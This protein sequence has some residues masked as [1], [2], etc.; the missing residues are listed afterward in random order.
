MFAYRQSAAGASSSDVDNVTLN[1]V[2]AGSL[3]VVF[4]YSFYSGGSYGTVTCSDGTS[5]SECTPAV[6]SYEYIKAF[7]QY[8][9]GGG[10]K[11]Y[12]I[13]GEH[14]YYGVCAFEF[15]Y[16]GSCKLDAQ[17]QGYGDAT[18]SVAT[19]NITTTGAGSELVIA[20]AVSYA[21]GNLNTPR[22]N[23][24]AAD[25]SLDLAIGS[26]D[27]LAWYRIVR[28]TFTGNASCTDGDSGY[29]VANVISFKEITAAVK[30]LPPQLLTPQQS[31]QHM[32]VR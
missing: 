27:G 31:I 9:S 30:A 14:D 19:G 11:T 32:L 24:V 2:Q 16:A 21:S 29:W 5:L 4:F 12:T 17:N 23:N 13:T 20:C 8:S 7:Y 28:S 10:N 25:G 3:I 6:G 22:I 18:G 1:S 15:S 26:G